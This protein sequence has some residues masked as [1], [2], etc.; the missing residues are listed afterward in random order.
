MQQRYHETLRC[1]KR[2]RKPLQFKSSDVV[3]I[4]TIEWETFIVKDNDGIRMALWNLDIAIMVEM[5]RTLN[6]F[7]SNNGESSGITIDTI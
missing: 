7:D 3:D 2:Q 4:K 1:Y 5:I 6:I